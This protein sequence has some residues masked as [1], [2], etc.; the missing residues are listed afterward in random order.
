M[1]F[2]INN[3][4]ILTLDQFIILELRAGLIGVMVAS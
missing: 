3:L 1:E 4:D 2:V